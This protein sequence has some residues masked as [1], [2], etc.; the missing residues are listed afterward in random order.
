MDYIT[1]KFKYKVAQR[2]KEKGWFFTSYYIVFDFSDQEDITCK[3]LTHVFRCSLQDYLTLPE[4][5]LL[6]MYTEDNKTWYPVTH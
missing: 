5:G 3:N 6:N 4:K 1:K 2:Y